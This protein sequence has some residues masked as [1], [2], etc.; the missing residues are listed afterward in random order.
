[1]DKEKQKVYKIEQGIDLDSVYCTTYQ[2][3][4]FYRQLGD[5]FFSVLDIM[6]YIQHQIIVKR[7]CK[8]GKHVLDICC[9]R[10]LLLPML[11]YERKNLGSYTG[12]DIE[13]KNAKFLNQRVTDGKLIGVDYYPFPVKFI[14]GDVAVMSEKLPIDY[15]DVLI[16]M[17]SIEHMHKEVGARSLVECYKVAKPGA[18]LIIT[19]PNTSM[20][21]SGYDT[22]YAAHVYEWKR[23]ELVQELN[24][25]G[26]KIIDEWG[27]LLDGK[28][29]AKELEKLGLYGVIDKLHKFVPSEW[30]IPVL[31]VLFPMA[32]KEIGF[33]AC[34]VV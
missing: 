22:Q 14:E 34:K 31:S 24:K 23:D 26:F 10:G 19:C 32:S 18:I 3:R 16:Y 17:S 12:I 20:D 28:V 33:V 21:K 4:N 2:M 15:Y 7:Y 27:L 13:R 11:R 9:G 29:L 8:A 6:N 5:G 25:A 1:M 30:Y